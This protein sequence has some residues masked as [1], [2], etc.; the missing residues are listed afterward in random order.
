MVAKSS[1]YG[2]PALR[3]S[4]LVK[5]VFS[6]TNSCRRDKQKSTG[7]ISIIMA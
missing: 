4:K 1:R 5:D 2:F 7:S 3:L 6:P